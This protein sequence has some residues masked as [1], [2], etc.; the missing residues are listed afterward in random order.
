MLSKLEVHRTTGIILL[1]RSPGG[2]QNFVCS[3]TKNWHVIFR[4]FL[5]KSSDISAVI[6]Y[7]STEHNS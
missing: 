5:Y 6:V 4:V 2:P 7:F 3:R 1:L